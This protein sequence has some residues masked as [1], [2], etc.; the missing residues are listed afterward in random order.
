MLSAIYKPPLILQDNT[1]QVRRD[2]MVLKIC[3]LFFSDDGVLKVPGVD[4][5]KIF[6]CKLAKSPRGWG[7]FLCLAEKIKWKKAPPPWG[8]SRDTP[9]YASFPILEYLIPRIIIQLT[10]IIDFIIIK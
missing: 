2:G 3:T 8:F 10:V 6:R 4:N 5:K 7:F 9:V 1:S